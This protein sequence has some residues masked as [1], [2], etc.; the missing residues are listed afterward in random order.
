MLDFG[1]KM[2]IYVN[3]WSKSAD[4]KGAC[5]KVILDFE[6]KTDKNQKNELKIT[7]RHNN[8]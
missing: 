8:L 3:L 4:E 2:G 7:Q 1:Q 5:V 6:F